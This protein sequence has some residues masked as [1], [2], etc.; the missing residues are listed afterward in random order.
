[1]H[2]PLTSTSPLHAALS[3]YERT[4]TPLKKGH[5]AE[6]S[7]LRQLSISFLGSQL[8]G[9]ITRRDIGRYRDERLAAGRAASTVRAEL[10]LLSVVFRWLSDD[11]DL[12]IANP[13]AR[14]R[15]PRAPNAR[16]R[17]I[18]AGEWLAILERVDGRVAALLTLLR[19][20]GMRRGELCALRWEDV[21]LGRRI[22][23]VK[24]SKNGHARTVPLSRTAV[25]ALQD[26][27]V[28]P[29][30]PVASVLPGT[31]S[32]LFRK[33]A[34][35][36]GAAD[37]RL[38]DLRRTAVSELLEAGLDVTSVAAISG[39]RTLQTLWRHYAQIKAEALV[40]TLDS[41]QGV[42]A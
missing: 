40:A 26:L 36:S 25:S 35:A 6:T 4:V 13:V 33:A 34:R 12:D 27:G 7:R 1:M 11:C 19:A 17:R 29:T 20:T 23:L 41:M 38:H 16:S 24:V 28:R 2:L 5:E 31:L 15:K 10:S 18:E 32:S 39:H 22:A 9:S 8:L 30:G 42:T 14:I 3:S 21:D 37:L